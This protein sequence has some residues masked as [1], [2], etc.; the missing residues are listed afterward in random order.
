MDVA[1]DVVVADV[2]SASFIA[3]SVCSSLNS[4][5]FK[6]NLHLQREKR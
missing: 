1:A 6:N 5:S 4:I 3:A 2:V